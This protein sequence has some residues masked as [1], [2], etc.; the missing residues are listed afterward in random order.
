MDYNAT[1]QFTSENKD[2]AISEIMAGRGSSVSKSH[3]DQLRYRAD[4][5]GDWRAKQAIEKLDKK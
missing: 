1:G 5:L 2:A 4:H 3:Q